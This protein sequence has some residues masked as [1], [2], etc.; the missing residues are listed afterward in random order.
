MVNQRAKKPCREPSCSE[1]TKE[2]YCSKH[3]RSPNYGRS[4]TKMGYNYKWQ[5]MSKRFLAMHPLCVECNRLATLVD[6]RVPHKGNEKLFW[7][8]SN[9]QPMC[10]SCHNRKTATEDMGSWSNK[11]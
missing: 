8:M 6:H 2:A 4:S 3:K 7:D 9:W 5:K 11:L 10:T 1:L